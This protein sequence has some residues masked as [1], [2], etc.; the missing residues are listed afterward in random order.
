[1]I[2][3]EDLFKAFQTYMRAEQSIVRAHSRLTDKFDPDRSSLEINKAR[4]KLREV[5]DEAGLDID[6]SER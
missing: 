6:W 5:C 4:A 2:H 3:I 1:M